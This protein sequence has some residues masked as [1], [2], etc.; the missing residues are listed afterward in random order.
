LAGRSHSLWNAIAYSL[1]GA[2]PMKG[3]LGIH[4]KL[5]FDAEVGV[6][7]LGL[8]LVF[9][10]GVWLWWKSHRSRDPEQDPTA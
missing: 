8:N 4:N 6:V 9:L 5:L 7:G 2:G 3:I 10:I 1:F